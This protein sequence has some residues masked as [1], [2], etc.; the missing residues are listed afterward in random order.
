MHE[1]YSKNIWLYIPA[2]RKEREKVRNL[3]H[4]NLFKGFYKV[5]ENVAISKGLYKSVKQLTIRKASTEAKERKE[6]ENMDGQ[7]VEILPHR[8]LNRL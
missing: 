8:K 5:N 2:N 1:I 4:R 6:R 3:L 7:A